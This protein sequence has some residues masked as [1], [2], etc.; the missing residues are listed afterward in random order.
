MKDRSLMCFEVKRF[1]EQS[2]FSKYAFRMIINTSLKLLLNLKLLKFNLLQQSLTCR[3][4][5]SD[6]LG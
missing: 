1:S 4:T 6:L 5:S 3:N 2:C